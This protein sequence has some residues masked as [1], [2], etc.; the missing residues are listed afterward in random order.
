MTAGHDNNGANSE[1]DALVARAIDSVVIVDDVHDTFAENGPTTDEIEDLWSRVEFDNGALNEI[2]ALGVPRPTRMEDLSGSLIDRLRQNSGVCPNFD[3][4]WTSSVL[5]VVHAAAVIPVDDLAALVTE[6]VGTELGVLGSD[7]EP[8]EIAKLRPQLVFMDWRMGRSDQEQAV[9]TAVN[10]ATQILSACTSIGIDKPLIVLISSNVLSD[11]AINDFCRR[12][13]ILRGMFYAVNKAILTDPVNFP[14]YMHLFESSLPAGRKIQSFMDRL[15]NSFERLSATFLDHISD[16]TLADYAFVQSM[17]LRDDSQ[18]LGDY[19]LWLFSTYLG[20]L[21]LTDPLQGVRADLDA[22]LW[23]GTVPSLAPPSERLNELYRNALYDMSVDRV[24][25]HPL[26]GQGDI[27]VSIVGPLGLGDIFQREKNADSGTENGLLCLDPWSTVNPLPDPNPDVMMLISPQCDL[28]CRPE[29]VDRNVVLIG[30]TLIPFQDRANQRDATITDLFVHQDNHY[31]IVWNLKRAETVVYRD[32]GS[33][34]NLRGYQREARLRL[35]FALEIQRA[36]AADFTRIGTR[37][38]PPIYQPLA[39]ELER[40]NRQLNAYENVERFDN[41]K[42]AFL[43]LTKGGQQCVLTTQL[44]TGLKSILSEELKDMRERGGQPDAPQ[45]L[46]QQ[47]IALENVLKDQS[48]WS[49]LQSPF[50]LPRVNSPTNF[51]DGWVQVVLGDAGVPTGGPKP[52][53]VVRIEQ[54]DANTT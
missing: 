19:L 54:N 25:S 22:T 37:I 29:N 51:I 11:D 43:M 46:P 40:A 7:C 14:M 38:A 23:D 27:P 17:S 52:V 10:K 28:E 5:G 48:K 47:I 9:Q 26:A 44:S 33:W 4:I 20:Q 18:P 16:L 15:T 13:R 6:R 12:S 42:G 31:A 2:A 45:Y 30:G 36:F 39:M 34:L 3:R 41:G 24:I 8:S 50:H 21:L 32:F 49:E 1:G 53:A 35:P